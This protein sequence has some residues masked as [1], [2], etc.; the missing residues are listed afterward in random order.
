[1]AF[2]ISITWGVD[3]V[4]HNVN[5]SNICSTISRYGILNVTTAQSGLSEW[6]EEPDISDKVNP[7]K[8]NLL[9]HQ[10]GLSW[11]QLKSCTW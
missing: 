11:F 7:P 2:G 6:D 8:K 9:V 10:S 1:M 4:Y 5:L 3:N